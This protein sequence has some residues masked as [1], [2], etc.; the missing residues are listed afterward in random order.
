MAL[1]IDE[2]AYRLLWLAQWKLQ[3]ESEHMEPMLTKMIGHLSVYQ[4]AAEYMEE[5]DVADVIFGKEEDQSQVLDEFSE[6][7]AHDAH[8]RVFQPEQASSS[9]SSLPA[10]TP[11]SVVVSAV[12]VDAE[13]E[14]EGQR[15]PFSDDEEVSSVGEDDVNW[16]SDDETEFGS[17]SSFD[18]E[19]EAA[20]HCC[21][22]TAGRHS[23]KEKTGDVDMDPVWRPKV[24][25][26]AMADLPPDFDAWAP[27][28]PPLGRPGT[29]LR[30]TID[31]LAL[32]DA[33]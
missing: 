14:G 10:T 29:P 8:N 2:T 30:A 15:N 23:L 26:I 28:L 16:S 31:G 9:S 3:Q 20:D 22:D 25:D 24:R 1:V 12:E 18:E 27:S 13:G 19:N 5:H 4:K 21:G 6:L 32:V 11:D 17:V 7:L 33:S